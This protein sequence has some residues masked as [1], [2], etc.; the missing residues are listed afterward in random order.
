MRQSASIRLSLAFVLVA[1]VCLLFA[2]LQISTSN[3]WQ[4]L[5]R[6]ALGVVTP[7]FTAVDYLG[8]AVI[9]TLAFASSEWR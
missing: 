9:R 7:D 2:D 5:G 3:P 6:L 4:E 8:Q 1:F